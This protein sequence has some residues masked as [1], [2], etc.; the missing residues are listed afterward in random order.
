LALYFV[1]SFDF[2]TADAN[3]ESHLRVPANS[4]QAGT[5]FL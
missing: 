2:V 5:L 3:W 1:F 4:L